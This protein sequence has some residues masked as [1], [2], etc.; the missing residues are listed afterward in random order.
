MF[1]TRREG[2]INHVILRARDGLLLPAFG[3]H[4]VDNV[5]YSKHDYG[6]DYSYR[7]S[8]CGVIGAPSSLY[9]T[10]GPTKDVMRAEQMLNLR[11]RI[12][13][14][15]VLMTLE[16]GASLTQHALPDRTIVRRASI[17]DT[18]RLLSLRESYEME[19]VVLDP[20]RFNRTEC[21]MRLQH[22]LRKELLY[23]AEWRGDPVAIAATNARG[24]MV[25][26]IGGVFTD[27]SRRRTGLG[28]AVMT[29]LLQNIFLT[30]Q[31]ACL[32]VKTGNLAAIKLYKRL[33]F[34]A[35]GGY[36]ISYYS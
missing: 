18:A 14:D 34:I 23:V 13:I 31:Q 21:R 7:R 33:G 30:K 15:H 29:A 19:E 35:R 27:L 8:F 16:R 11:P 25:D 10:M 26:Q 32:F 20:A 22:S 2:T 28:T 9:S 4:S 24:I 5:H 36:I 1:A 6:L 17:R 3:N 12:Q